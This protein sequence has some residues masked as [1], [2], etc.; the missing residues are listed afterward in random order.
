MNYQI[1]RC[2]FVQPYSEIKMF[3]TIQGVRK[4]EERYYSKTC[5]TYDTVQH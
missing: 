2:F 3:F 4:K 1:T 5:V